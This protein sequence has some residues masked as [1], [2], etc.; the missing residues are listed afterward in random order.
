MS[1]N[2]NILLLINS[3]SILDFKRPFKLIKA[4]LNLHLLIRN[5][6]KIVPYVFLMGMA[7]VH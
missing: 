2:Y 7:G 4:E 1:V 3:W 6:K 5:K